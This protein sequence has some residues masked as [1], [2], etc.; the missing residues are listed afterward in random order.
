MINSG[1]MRPIQCWP[2]GCSSHRDQEI[3]ATKC[4]VKLP[5]DVEEISI[6]IE[7]LWSYFVLNQCPTELSSL[8]IICNSSETGSWLRENKYLCTW[9]CHNKATSAFN[10]LIISQAYNIPSQSAFCPRPPTHKLRRANVVCFGNLAQQS[11]CK[12]D[13]PRIMLDFANL[14]HR[15]LNPHHLSIFRNISLHASLCAFDCVKILSIFK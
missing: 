4:H 10:A 13:K 11:C 15:R 6:G 14:E 3:L 2:W 9:S 12:L 8:V 7:M 1:G 5:K